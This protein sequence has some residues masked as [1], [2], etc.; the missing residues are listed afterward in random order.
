[1]SRETARGLLALFEAHVGSGTLLLLGGEPLLDWPVVEIFA[2]G[3]PGNVILFTNATLVDEPRARFLARHRVKVLVSL[4]GPPPYD[5]DRRLRDGRPMLDAT[6]TG[7]RRLS[8]AGVDLGVSCV[9]TSRNVA[10]LSTIA[11]WMRSEM[12]ARTIGFS[13]PH[14]TRGS[15]DD[16]DPEAYA[17][18]LVEL[19]LATKG[20]GLYIPQ[21][22]Q[23][24]APLLT[25]RGRRHSCL[26][27]GEQ[28]TFLPDGRR[29]LCTK[30]ELLPTPLRAGD[31]RALRAASPV[32]NPDCVS[33][34]WRLVCGGG[35]YWDGLERFG[36]LVDMRECRLL[37]TLVPAL[38]VDMA[39][40]FEAHGTSWRDVY[41]GMIGA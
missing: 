15:Q 5:F 13:M 35:C 37:E 2:A 9:V 14:A 11:A 20:T 36:R 21:I 27:A 40:S 8:E 17:G 34:P 39:R 12:Q 25:R 16:L 3:A 7:W 4:D 18:A 29:T 23:R 19:F 26:A 10:A 32:V 33:C 38:L 1:M 22:G 6:L 31:E 30:L 28:W 24:L 41:D